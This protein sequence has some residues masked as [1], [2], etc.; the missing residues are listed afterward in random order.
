MT[1]RTWQTPK[2]SLD[3]LVRCAEDPVGTPTWWACLARHLDELRDELAHGDI[4]GLATQITT[5]A[6]HLAAAAARLP[7]LD[8]HVQAE[9]TQLRRGLAAATGSQSA[10]PG[11]RDALEVALRHVRTLCRMSDDLMLDAYE[12]DFGGE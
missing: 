8:A 10:A 4:E 12:R 1:V 3:H 7:H 2:E 5:D 6:P 11:I 9:L